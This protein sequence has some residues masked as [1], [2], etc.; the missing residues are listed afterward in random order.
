MALILDL[1][2]AVAAQLIIVLWVTFA[3]VAILLYCI[4]RRYDHWRRKGVRFDPARF[5]FGSFTDIILRRRSIG[6]LV[7]EIYNNYNEPVVGL[8]TCL[9]PTLMIRDP[10]IVRRIFNMD[11]DTFNDRMASV[12]GRKLNRMRLKLTPSFMTSKLK[13]MFSTL[14]DCGGSLDAFLD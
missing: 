14:V 9:T 6:E 8:W 5:P 1:V 4:H 3:V 13:G 11:F 7:S 2:L 12:V 10:K